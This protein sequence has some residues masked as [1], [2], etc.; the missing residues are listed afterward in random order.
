MIQLLA[1]R[2]AELELADNDGRLPVHEA[3]RS[4]ALEALQVHMFEAL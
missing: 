4:G 1:S 2:G 3:A